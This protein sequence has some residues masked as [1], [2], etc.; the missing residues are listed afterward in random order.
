VKSLQEWDSSG[1]GLG[2]S[3]ELQPVMLRGSGGREAP[4]DTT[5]VS[6][7]LRNR[8]SSP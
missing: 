2:K 8:P 7:I 4:L 1:E 6:F 3:Q 5:T